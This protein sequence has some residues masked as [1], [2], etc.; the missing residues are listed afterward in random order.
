MRR[1]L[2]LLASLLLGCDVPPG[3]AADALLHPMRRPSSGAPAGAA[4]F[5]VE[6]EPGVALRGWL[7]RGFPPR[8]GLILYLHGVGDNKDSAIGLATRY[9]PRGWDVAAYDARAHGESGGA[10]CTYG[11]YEKR[12][13]ARVLDTLQASG[14]RVEPTI[15]F[16]ASMGAA[17][18]LQAAPLDGRVRAVVAQSPFA[19]L[20][21]AVRAMKPFF[22]SHQSV[23]LARLVAEERARFQLAGVSPLASVRAL[24]VP[25]L[26]VHGTA[27]AKLPVENSRRLLAAAASADKTL[28]EIAGGGHDDL[29]SRAETWQAIDPFIDRATR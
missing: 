1:A 15:L 29:W 19:D 20:D 16:G 8:R 24:G 3:W 5:A 21:G 25:L 12:D 23:V 26:L 17:V 10:N 27:D 22:L 4:P 13:V 2:V 9:G 11:F 28:I 14:A 6:V 18:A 7:A